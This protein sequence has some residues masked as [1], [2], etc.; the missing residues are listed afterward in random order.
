MQAQSHFAGRCSIKVLHPVARQDQ[1]RSLI[2]ALH[3]CYSSGVWTSGK[4]ME[5]IMPNAGQRE[6]WG[7]LSRSFLLR[8]SFMDEPFCLVDHVQQHHPNEQPTVALSFWGNP[9]ILPL[10]AVYSPH[11]FASVRSQTDQ[12]T[13]SCKSA[14]ETQPTFRISSHRSYTLSSYI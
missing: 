7:A 13:R 6:G 2:Q 10:K 1:Q 11:T 8:K 14:R 4:G 5:R 3:S 9:T 12:R